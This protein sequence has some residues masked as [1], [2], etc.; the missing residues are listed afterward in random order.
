MGPGLGQ[1][2]ERGA[3]FLGHRHWRESL[4]IDRKG[5]APQLCFHHLHRH[6]DTLARVSALFCFTQKMI[7]RP[8]QSGAE[9]ARDGT[10]DLGSFEGNLINYSNSMT[11]DLVS[12]I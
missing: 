3:C 11:L 12:E 10:F 5:R 4:H 6:P 8:Y 9:Q 7:M 2:S 1:G